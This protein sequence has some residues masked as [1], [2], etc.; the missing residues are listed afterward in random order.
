MRSFILGLCLV[1][2][3]SF[4]VCAAELLGSKVVG[5][6]ADTDIINVPGQQTFASIQ[7]CVKKRT[8]QFHDV[9]VHFANGGHQDLQ[10]AELIAPGGCTRWLDLSGGARN[11]T[12]I[13]LRYD[14]QGNIGP[15]AFVLV[16]GR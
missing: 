13:V 12:K 16:Y 7:L 15:Q 5:D 1:A 9:D 14:T 11:I 6:T 10:V 4:G 2:L 8:V 3:S